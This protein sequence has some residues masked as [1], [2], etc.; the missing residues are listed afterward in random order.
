MCAS[1]GHWSGVGTL[2]VMHPVVPLC[3]ALV[4]LLP[5]AMV[6]AA[7]QMG[8]SGA[9]GPLCI[10]GD[11]VFVLVWLCCPVGTGVS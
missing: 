3:L 9:G 2:Y 4:G 1:S 8:T 10:C 7:G 11:G 6:G 5:L